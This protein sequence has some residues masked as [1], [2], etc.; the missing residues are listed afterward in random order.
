MATMKELRDERLRKLEELRT[1][2]IDPYPATSHRTHTAGQIITDFDKLE[3]KIATVTGRLIN[4]RK[5]GKIA[6]FV[7]RDASGEIQLFL[8]H[9]M[10]KVTDPTI[11][12]LSFENL[13]LLD[14]GD[15]IETTGQVIKTQTGEISLEVQSIRLLTK[16]L[17]PLPTERD[18]FHD[19]EA[20]Y[21][22]R[23]VDMI[24]NPEVKNSLAVRSRIVE[25]SRQFLIQKGFEEIETPVLQPMYG[26]ASARPFTTYHH[27]LESTLYLRISDEL[28]LK[29]AVVGGFEKVFEVGKDFRNE[30]IDRSHNPE[31]TMIEFYWAYADYE[32]LITL[33]EEFLA[34][35]VMGIK[36]S[37]T[38]EYQG[39]QLDFA[40]PYRRVTLRDLVL[41]HTGI[42]IDTITR[43]ELIAEIK[44][45]KIDIDLSSDPPMN[46]L[47]DEFYK[48]TTRTNV[49]QPIFL[50]DYPATM[51]P[52]AK[53]KIDNANK[54]ASMQVVVAGF[55]IIKAYNELNDPIDQLNRWQEEQQALDDGASEVAQPIDYDYIRA[56]EV[57]MPPTAGWGMGVDRLAAFL[58]DQPSIKDTIMFPTLRPEIFDITE[59]ASKGVLVTDGKSKG[60]I[61]PV[62]D[63]STG[64][65]KQDFSSKMIAVVNKEL[66]PW[67]VANAVAH[68]SAIIGNKTE[69]SKLTSGDTFVAKDGSAI[70]R[71]SQYPVVIKRASEKELHKLYESLRE[72]QVIYHVFTKEMQDTTD[73]NEISS[74]MQAQTLADTVFYGVMFLAPHEQADSLTKKYQ[75]WE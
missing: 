24:V 47:L 2:G 30:G 40:P 54:A 13:N 41:E 56:L 34:S 50:L 35:I 23:Y 70:P 64:I 71:N 27:K 42:D 51:L 63:T 74:I 49:T 20:R 32:D 16:S 4:T 68:M 8:K 65:Q 72:T 48:E 12:Q 25:L 29:R 45:R 11:G 46:D 33:T 26:G 21:R 73:D 67:R 7:I 22:Q 61:T 28:Y 17:R 38:F 69:A 57:G 19:V 10:V 14:P 9:D 31:F 52:L 44:T 3:S 53:R 60:N 5:F 37:Y 55:E 36:G 6:F 43:E 62:S 58:T 59:Y 75:L 15:F 18:G 66:E 1:L 39:Q